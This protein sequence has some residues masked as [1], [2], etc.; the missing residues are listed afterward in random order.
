MAGLQSE[1]VVTPNNGT[2][3][4]WPAL[5]GSLEAGRRSCNRRLGAAVAGLWSLGFFEI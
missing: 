3:R 1:E 5:P 2:S 4:R